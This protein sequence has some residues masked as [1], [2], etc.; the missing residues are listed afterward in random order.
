[1]TQHFRHL[2]YSRKNWK[3][4]LQ[5]KTT[6]MLVEAP[7]TIVK[8]WKQFK[9]PSA[10]GWINKM[11]SVHPWK[12]YSAIRKNKALNPATAGKGIVSTAGL[13]GLAPGCLK[14]EKGTPSGLEN[15]NCRIPEFYE[16]SWV[17]WLSWTSSRCLTWPVK[18]TQVTG[19]GELGEL[20]YE[21]A[22]WILCWICL[23][24]GKTDLT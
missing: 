22:Q 13:G 2:V 15:T 4:V 8:R 7:V 23:P 6:Q 19:R 18:S 17:H 14:F 16:K 11:C 12:C 21:S 9:C 3:Q 24:C 5:Q 10:V 20:S 1:M